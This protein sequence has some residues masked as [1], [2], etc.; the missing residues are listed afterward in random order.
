MPLKDSPRSSRRQFFKKT[1]ALTAT[2]GLPTILPHSVFGETAPSNRIVLGFIGCGK[3]SKHLLR[4]FLQEPGTQV[5]S[6]CDVDK[7]KLDR[8]LYIAT[9]Y[10]E[11]ENRSGIINGIQTT[12]DYRDILIRD[13]I[14]AVVV[15]TP[16]HWHGLHVVHSAKSGFDIYCEKPLAHNIS[17]GQAMVNAVRKYNRVFQTGSMQRSDSKFRHACELVRNGYIGDIQH[18]AVNIGGPPVPCDLPPMSVPDYL[19][20][21]MWLGPAP[22][23]PYHAELSPHLSNDVFPNWRNY[24]EFGGGGMTDWGAHHFDIAQWGLGMDGSGPVKVYPPDG[25]EIKDLTYVYANG[26]TMTR[27]NQYQGI[28]VNG[29]LFVGSKGKVMVNRGFLQTWPESLQTQTISPGEIHLY[30]SENH[31]G[32]FLHAVRSRQQPICDVAT[33]YSTVVVCLMGNIAYELGR[34][35]EFDQDKQVFVNDEEANTLM[36]RPMGESWAL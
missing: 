19:D 5:V 18:V 28:R 31:Y 1:L 13:D 23:H 25:E 12:G 24:R 22:E 29:L 36:G 35:L 10:Y 33:G 3:Q 32:D 8:D 6:L 26:V 4:A 15:S 16:D 14:D 2:V 27:T 11:R 9:S 21:P 7:L 17:E 30:Q 34:P 20:W